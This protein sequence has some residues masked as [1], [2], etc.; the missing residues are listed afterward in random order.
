M[1]LLQYDGSGAVWL[2]SGMKFTTIDQDND[3][4][5]DNCATN[6]EGGWWYNNCF[7]ACVTCNAVAH[8]WDS[9]GNWYLT[10]SRMMIK[11]HD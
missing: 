4:R 8:E 7:Y 6:R 1:Q 9:L 3:L 2:H 11:P 10:N 5:F